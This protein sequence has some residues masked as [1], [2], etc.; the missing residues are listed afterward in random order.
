M[1]RKI[2]LLLTAV[3]LMSCML[4]ACD[5]ETEANSADSTAMSLG[6][7]KPIE[8]NE[9]L[10]YSTKTRV[11]YY[12]FSTHVNDDTVER[13]YGYSYFAPYISE[14]GCFCRY[15]DDMIIEIETKN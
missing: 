10:V 12:M 2:V 4:T 15:V 9:S 11:V 13:G 5:G 8:G 3:A 7:F 14:N 6:D 1:K